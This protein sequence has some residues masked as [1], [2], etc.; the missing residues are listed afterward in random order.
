MYIRKVNA[1]AVGN[2]VN[3]REIQIFSQNESADV[4]SLQQLRQ[5]G[6]N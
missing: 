6:M 1:Q 2:N 5:T 4:T 3:L